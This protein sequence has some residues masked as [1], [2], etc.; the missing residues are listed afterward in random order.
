MQR[1]GSITPFGSAVDPLVNCRMASASGSSAGR[2][3]AVGGRAAEVVERHDRRVAGLRVDELGAARGRR[4]RAPASALAIRRRVCST[5]SSIEPSR[6]GSGRATT[7]PPV[8]HIAWIAVTYGRGRRAEQGDVGAGADAAT[9]E[10]GRHR[11]GVV[12]QPPPTRLRSSPSAPAEPTNVIVR[13]VSA[14]ASRRGS[15]EEVARG[16]RHR[17]RL[18]SPAPPRALR[19]QR[20]TPGRGRTSSGGGRGRRRRPR[21][22]P[23]PPGCRGGRRRRCGRSA[24]ATAGRR[25]CRRAGRGRR[26]PARRRCT[27]R[28]LAH[29]AHPG[30]RGA[31]LRPVHEVVDEPAGRLA[32]RSAS[33]SRRRSAKPPP[34]SLA[35]SLIARLG[36]DQPGCVDRELG[37][38]LARLLRRACASARSRRGRRRRAGPRSSPRLS[39]PVHDLAA[40]VGAHDRERPVVERADA[41]GGDVGVLGREV[42]A[43]L[44]ALARPRVALLERHLVVVAVVH[45]DLEARP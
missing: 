43:H 37:P 28:P 3:Y 2:S 23:A 36:P 17:R 33:P 10:R 1:C 40:D 32:H 44:A 5:N 22:R 19:P 13:E 4:S 26:R 16:L 41:A 14:A 21:P 20:R 25:R 24:A 11:P 15:R 18:D 34:P 35:G 6:I 30:D 29:E 27:R 12:V 42:G 9:L 31:D 7:A 8:S 38:A 45:P 39:M